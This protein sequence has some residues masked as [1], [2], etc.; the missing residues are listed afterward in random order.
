MFLFFL[1][2]PTAS[3]KQ[4]SRRTA[5]STLKLGVNQ[6]VCVC[7]VLCDELMSLITPNVPLTRITEDG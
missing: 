7:M 4:A 1:I 6:C 5:N 3:Q 2:L